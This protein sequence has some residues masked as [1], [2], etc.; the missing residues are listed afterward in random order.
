VKN[1]A[2][3]AGRFKISDLAQ[4]VNQPPKKIAKLLKN[5]IDAEEIKGV[6]TVKNDEFVTLEQLKAEIMR[7]IKTPRLINQD[8]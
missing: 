2:I 3:E 8:L 4:I 5:M 7:V 6:F 1:F